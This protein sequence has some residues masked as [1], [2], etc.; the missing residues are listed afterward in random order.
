[1]VSNGPSP[2][3][4]AGPGGH[5]WG[6]RVTRL[7]RAGAL[8]LATELCRMDSSL[9]AVCPVC[10][11][12]EE[13][14]FHFAFKCW[15]YNE[16]REE[17]DGSAVAIL[18]PELLRAYRG[19]RG[20]EGM[21]AV[22]LDGGPLAWPRRFVR[23]AWATLESLPPLGRAQEKMNPGPRGEWMEKVACFMAKAWRMRCKV[24]KPVDRWTLASDAHCC[25]EL[26]HRVRY[27]S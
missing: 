24:L 26:Y 9:D 14:A 13:T 17:L 27:P 3:Q 22:L 10:R 1:M 23:P 19:E 21:M 2:R 11:R 20:A 18:P 7:L 15:M 16:A 5:P 8:P 4:A 6:H 12:E 25:E